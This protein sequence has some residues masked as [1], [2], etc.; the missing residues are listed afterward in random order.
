MA[1]PARHDVPLVPAPVVARPA[2]PKREALSPLVH[3]SDSLARRMAEVE[4]EEERR[5][6]ENVFM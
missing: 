6:A 4:D 1:A 2:S 3:T 5:L